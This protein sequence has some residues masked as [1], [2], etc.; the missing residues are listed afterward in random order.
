MTSIYPWPPC[1]DGTHI[2][3]VSSSTS[4]T[5]VSME[6]HYCMCGAMVIRN[7]NAFPA[8]FSI[9]SITETDDLRARVE[10]LEKLIE[11]LR[12]GG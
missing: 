10:R 7:G 4:A 11:L 5:G 6:G 2:W 12:I 1:H 9:S 8:T 3:N